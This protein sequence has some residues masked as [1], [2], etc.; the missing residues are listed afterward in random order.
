MSEQPTGPEGPPDD[1]MGEEPEEESG[2]GYGN[3][4]PDVAEESGKDDK[5]G[6]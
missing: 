4:A 5:D 2:A 6:R 1:A 3:H